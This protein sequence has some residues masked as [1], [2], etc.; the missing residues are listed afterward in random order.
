MFSVQDSTQHGCFKTR[1]N[2]YS[3][4]NYKLQLQAQDTRTGD[5]PF[6]SP[7]RRSETRDCQRLSPLNQM[8]ELG[9]E[10]MTQFNLLSALHIQKKNNMQFYNSEKQEARHFGLENQTDFSRE[11][12]KHTGQLCNQKVTQQWDNDFFGNAGCVLSFRDTTF[13]SLIQKQPPPLRQP[14]GV[15]ALILYASVWQ[16]N[17]C[18]VSV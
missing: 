6:I 18:Q 11:I 15:R 2:H 8:A 17:R 13:L 10:R 9:T 7:G 4:R 1:G 12:A 14:F 16:P 3:W 5:F